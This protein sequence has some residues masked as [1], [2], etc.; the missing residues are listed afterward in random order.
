MYKIK[1]NLK[2]PRDIIKL[3]KS[4]SKDNKSS[5]SPNFRKKTIENKQE[6]TGI[7]Y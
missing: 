2:N 4:T 7:F 6:E 5:T 3:K 1:E